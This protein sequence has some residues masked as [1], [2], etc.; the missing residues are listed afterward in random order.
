[1]HIGTRLC[2][3]EI[4]TNC[5]VLFSVHYFIKS[6]Y[7]S[8][9]DFNNFGEMSKTLGQLFLVENGSASISRIG[10]LSLKVY[11]IKGTRH[12][13]NQSN[14]SWKYA[15]IIK[16][17]N[18]LKWVIA[19]VLQS[20]YLSRFFWMYINYWSNYSIEYSF[21]LIFPFCFPRDLHDNMILL[22]LWCYRY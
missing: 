21:H 10:F 11:L 13:F 12:I 18:F 1:M 22:S 3:I 15:K 14:Y 7:I 5:I 4:G 8:W 2:S 17:Y 9:R 20:D 19:K 6:K 16:E